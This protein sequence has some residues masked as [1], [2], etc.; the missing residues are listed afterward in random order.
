MRYFEDL[1]VGEKLVFQN[2][3]TVTEEEIIEV[4]SR[5]DP[6]PFHIDQEAAKASIFG[7]LTASSVHLFAMMVGIGTTDTKTEQMAAVSV[8]GFNNMRV[9][10]P[11]RPGD[12]LY[13]SSEVI[14]LRKSNSRPDCGIVETHN[15]MYN[16]DGKVVMS[17]DNAFLVQ[18]ANRSPAE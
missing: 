17:T 2:S 13:V 16:Q 14:K 1:K 18:C 5:W 12:V 9:T 6:Q 3:Y 8:L 15:E 11:A 4:A 7:S 10:H